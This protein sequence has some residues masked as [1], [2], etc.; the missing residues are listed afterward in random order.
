MNRHFEVIGEDDD[1][2]GDVMG[3]VMGYAGPMGDY[4]GGAQ[5]VGY[6]DAGE[7]IVVGRR[8]RR[9][10]GGATV[11]VRKPGWRQGQL[12]PGVIA[13]DQGLLPLPLGNFTFTATAQTNTFQGQ[14]QKPFR[15][16]RLLVTTVRTGTSS[17]GRL[18]GQI[19]VGS[20]LA[21]LDV[22]PI[23]LEQIGAA[24]A[25]GV[26]LTMKPAQP[27]VF[28]RIVTSLSGALAGADTIFATIQL[29]GRLV[30]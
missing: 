17:T 6:D 30:H 22:S 26:R 10:G 24:T 15:G 2:A 4:E 27:G 1:V 21:A 25:F 8:A 16:E 19:F 11:R 29:L 18:L 3:D 14:M 20:D 5:V 12:A 9:G 23:D 13:P 28:I 7:A